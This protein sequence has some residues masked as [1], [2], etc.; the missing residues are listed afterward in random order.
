MRDAWLLMVRCDVWFKGNGK[1]M[2]QSKGEMLET[3]ERGP[4]GLL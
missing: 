3:A 1:V 4:L 2:V